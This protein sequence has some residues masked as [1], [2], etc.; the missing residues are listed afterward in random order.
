[1]TEPN[2]Y[3]PAWFL[4]MKVR[5]E[6]FGQ[7]DDSDAQDG[8]KPF[9]SAKAKKLADAA[10]VEGQMAQAAAGGGRSRAAMVGL[11]ATVRALRRDA[12]KAGQESS[13]GPKG[14][15]DDF[16]VDFVTVP[17]EME[18]EDKG[19]FDADGLTAS[20]PF[21]DLPLHPLIIKECAVEAYVGTVKTEDFASPDR[22]HLSPVPSDTCVLWF[23]GYVDVPEM[24]HDDTSGVVHL[25]ARSYIAVLI[26]GK[27]NAKAKA[28]RIHGESEYIT[29]YINRILSLYPPTSGDTGGDPF[30]AY[31]YG[32]DPAKE[33]KLSRK[34]L[35]R[36]LQ[37]AA[38]RNA[39]AGQAPGTVVQ[40][41]PDPV[42]EGAD[43]GGAGDAAAGGTTAL[44]VKGA[45]EDGMSV[46]ELIVQA[47]ELCGCTP[48]YKPSLPAA[49]GSTAGKAQKVFPADC[50]LVVPPQAFLDDISGATKIA[51]GARDGFSREFANGVKSDVRFMV[52]GS[53]LSK[54]KMSRKLG[55][56]RPT[57]VEVRAYNPDASDTLRVMSSRF[58]R[59]LSKKKKGK[60]A[61]KAT[62]GTEK[63]GGKMDVVRT[64]VLRGIRDQGALD[65]AAASIYEQL[66]RPELSMEIETDELA[67]Y[68][69]PVESQSA[70]TL[71]KSHN[72]IPDLLKLCAGT[73]VHVTVANR[74]TDDA[75]LTICSLSEFY[76]LAANNIVELLTKQND[77]W[78][79]WRTDGSQDEAKI[80]ET[81]RKIQA[82]YRAAK[83]PT[84]Y[85]CA[86]IRLRFAAGDEFFHASMQLINYMPSN[87]PRNLDAVTQAINDDRN[88]KK[89]S[90]AGRAAD[91]TAK[92]SA[93]I[94]ER[95]AKL[96]AGVHR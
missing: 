89:T 52:W 72:D 2:T 51:G 32:G 43:A 45:T 7:S 30:R 90:R 47:C 49:T 53:N 55:K 61:G 56:V 22:W 44:P 79:A 68:M 38:S 26:D 94:T 29:E 6:D 73:P 92:R 34:T 16:S 41:Q 40:A 4:R 70:G 93:D 42:D 83:L 36:S 69:D 20:F 24:E 87:D 59:H 27:I 28:Y 85:Y 37:T 48:L 81:A 88:P 77:R 64:F 11:A 31:W 65:Q 39:A 8:S 82:A 86:G 75:G 17:T 58:P 18:L 9:L 46:W 95:G 76:D 19:F 1:M 63:G 91:N 5:L 25:K 15:G 57:A 10:V 74:S 12:A 62:K 66:C 21:Q 50:L 35:M 13:A 33:P 54:M 60:G 80:A 3:R 96:G 78:G 14:K 67:S 23:K 84:V 71:V